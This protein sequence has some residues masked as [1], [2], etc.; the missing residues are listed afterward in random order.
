MA[1]VADS[2]DCVRSLLG[3]GKC[4]KHDRSQDSDNGDDNQKFD[5]SEPGDVFPFFHVM[6][7]SKARV[8][9]LHDF[10]AMILCKKIWIQFDVR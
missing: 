5:Q 4:W 3:L 7:T 8:Y 1:F 10:F 6:A 9:F 2:F